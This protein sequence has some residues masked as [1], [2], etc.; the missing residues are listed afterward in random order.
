MRSRRSRPEPPPVGYAA[1][2]G[3][4]P[5]QTLR[6][7]AP[8]CVGAIEPQGHP[9]G[10]AAKAR[11]ASPNVGL[12]V[13]E[14]L[15]DHRHHGSQLGLGVRLALALRE[16]VL[17]QPQQ[18]GLQT[19]CAADTKR[20]AMCCTCRVRAAVN[21]T[22]ITSESVASGSRGEVEAL[23]C[24]LAAVELGCEPSPPTRRATHTRR[25]RCGSGARIAFGHT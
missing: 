20:S 2:G 9:R 11:L 7:E 3:L 18:N 16:H 12:G 15:V 4:A 25:L 1:R 14:E 13:D 21:P 10:A 5:T 17:E 24:A 8:T 6:S 22:S 23:G 19:G